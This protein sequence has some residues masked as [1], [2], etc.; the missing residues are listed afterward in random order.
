M[1]EL[2]SSYLNPAFALF[3]AVASLSAPTGALPRRYRWWIPVTLMLFAASALME[4]AVEPSP[5]IALRFL[6]A[7]ASVVTAVI[8]GIHFERVRVWSRAFRPQAK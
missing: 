7:A 2:I 6:L 5:D 4:L 1:W 8:A 3:F